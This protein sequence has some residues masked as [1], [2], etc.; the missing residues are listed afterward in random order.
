MQLISRT[1]ATA[2]AL[3]LPLTALT[4]CSSSVE[5]NPAGSSTDAQG[6][7]ASAQDT[8]A[9]GAQEQSA[10]TEGPSSVETGQ[11]S[12]EDLAQETTPDDIDQYTSRDVALGL[13]E[14]VVPATDEVVL[15]DPEG[16]DEGSSAAVVRV[17]AGSRAV[18]VDGS[19]LTVIIDGDIESLTVNGI[20]NTVWVSTVGTV[21]F[22][23]E[24]AENEV[25]W[26]GQAPTLGAAGSGWDNHI[27]SD[28]FAVYVQYYCP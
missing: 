24:A 26:N 25:F 6:A 11:C 3:L 27:A 7:S 14:Q 10:Q 5:I 18:R 8:T 28:E 16:D 2:C 13:V 17:E 22:G 20:D 15:D 21:D 1:A 19:A 23:E 9:D 4:A 12:Q